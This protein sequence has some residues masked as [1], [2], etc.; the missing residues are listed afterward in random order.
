MVKNGHP[1]SLNP[2]IWREA[3]D[4]RMFFLRRITRINELT[5]PPLRFGGQ[6]RPP[7]QRSG[8][9]ARLNGVRAGNQP[10]NDYD[11]YMTRMAQGK[12]S[13]R[14]DHHDLL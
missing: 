11:A 8:R 4:A 7:E 3:G 1:A 6:V 12:G 13:V 14:A 2:A 10:M 9:P 5:P